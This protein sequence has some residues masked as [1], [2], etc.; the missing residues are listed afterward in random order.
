MISLT[1]CG[2]KDKVVSLFS[3]DEAEATDSASVSAET[4]IDEAW[5]KDSL[6]RAQRITPD[7]AFFN[8]HGPVKSL[9]EF[10]NVYIFDEN[11]K[12]V[13]ANGKNPFDGDPYEN[14]DFGSNDIYMKRGKDGRISEEQGWESVTEYTWEG[15]RLVGYHGY[16]EGAY[17]WQGKYTYGEDGLI[18]S[19]KS[20]EGDA[21]SGSTSTVVNST[22]KYLEKDEYGNW[23]KLKVTASDNSVRT[24]TI[25]YYPISGKKNK[26][27][28]NEEFDPTRS[29][30]SLKGI[31]G[32]DL[33][34]PMEIGPNGGNY[35]TNG[36]KRDIKVA[37]WNKSTGE[38]V[39]DAY[40]PGKSSRF[41]YF[42]GK[43]NRKTSPYTYSGTFYN[44][45]GGRVS[46]DLKVTS[47]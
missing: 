33:G 44:L 25:T 24:R 12:L 16:G 31:I 6:E 18:A 39:I 10:D 23:T 17:E 40:M 36:Q 26:T 34:C 45:N 20:K 30:F 3:S 4:A 11:G 22:Y 46:F 41:G 37:S 2:L 42:Q 47:M 38:L 9:K 27:T 5:Q 13:K 7:L 21:E 32:D 29:S 14:N 15:D 35:F 19:V 43:V 1:S 28:S 8:L